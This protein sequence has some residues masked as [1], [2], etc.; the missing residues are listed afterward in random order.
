MKSNVSLLVDSNCIKLERS[1]HKSPME[2]INQNLEKEPSKQSDSNG[3][4]SEESFN[5]ELV[6]VGNK[7][8]EDRPNELS[9]TKK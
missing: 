5:K 2:Y 6:S 9:S 1:D 7:E 4:V 8:N 3:V